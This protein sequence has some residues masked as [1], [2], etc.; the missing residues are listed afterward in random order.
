MSQEVTHKNC[1]GEI[2]ERTGKQ[3]KKVKQHISR[4]NQPHCKYIL[5]VKP[6]IIL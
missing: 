1:C 3:I 2:I 5:H 4:K 6:G